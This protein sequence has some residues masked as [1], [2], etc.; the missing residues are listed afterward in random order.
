MGLFGSHAKM[1]GV[2]GCLGESCQGLHDLSIVFFSDKWR[3]KYLVPTQGLRQ[4]DPLLPYLFL[5]CVEGLS[6]LIS[7]NEIDDSLHGLHI[8][9]S[10][11]SLHHMLF[12]DDNFL[13][14]QATMEECEV[15]Q[16][17]LDVYS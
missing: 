10:A 14:T 6:A 16:H 1:F 8:A 12:A 2:G 11:P 15:T 4:G 17:I 13:F 5:L 3:S 7:K 9:D